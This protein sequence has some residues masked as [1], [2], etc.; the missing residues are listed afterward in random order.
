MTNVTT[1]PEFLVS[2]KRE[3]SVCGQSFHT[4]AHQSARAYS[5]DTSG[6]T[7]AVRLVQLQV[8]ISMTQNGLF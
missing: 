4:Q 8:L 2:N 7:F 3:P 6:P 5:I 1:T